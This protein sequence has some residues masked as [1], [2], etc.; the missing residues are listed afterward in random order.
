MSHQGS[1][2]SS[3]LIQANGL[4]EMDIGT[5]LR[6]AGESIDVLVVGTI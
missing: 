5:R 1:G 6:S 4:A 2:M 3:S